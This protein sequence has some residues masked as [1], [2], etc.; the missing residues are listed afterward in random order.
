MAITF[1]GGIEL[2][3]GNRT[4]RSSPVQVGGYGNWSQIAA[5]FND[6]LAIR[7]QNYL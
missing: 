3:Q 5:G 4:N 1:G 2:G 7:S 6:S